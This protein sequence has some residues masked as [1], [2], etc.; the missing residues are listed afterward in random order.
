M[1]FIGSK[2]NGTPEVGAWIGSQLRVTVSYDYSTLPA[3]ARQAEKDKK[4]EPCVQV[5]GSVL[6]AAARFLLEYPHQEPDAVALDLLCEAKQVS[7]RAF[8]QRWKID[9]TPVIV[10][11]VKVLNFD[12]ISIQSLYELCQKFKLEPRGDFSAFEPAPTMG[13]FFGPASVSRIT[14]M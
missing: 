11:N 1:K 7:L 9:N 8:V 6:D 2:H 10:H 3:Q 12:N 14:S 4:I 5:R 13:Q